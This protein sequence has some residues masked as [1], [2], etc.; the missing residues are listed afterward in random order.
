MV[1]SRPSQGP[2]AEGGPLSAS[3]VCRAGP[4]GRRLGEGL[5][6][7]R[8]HQNPLDRGNWAEAGWSCREGRAA[9]VQ[10]ACRWVLAAGEAGG[11]S[12]KGPSGSG[13]EGLQGGRV[14]ASPTAQRWGHP[15][16]SRRGHE[17]WRGGSSLVPASAPSF[18]HSKK[19]PVSGHMPST[20]GSRKQDPQSCPLGLAIQ[21][22][23][24]MP[25]GGGG[26]AQGSGAFQT[27]VRTCDRVM[28]MTG[29]SPAGTAGAKA[30]GRGVWDKEARVAEEAA[31]GGRG[32]ETR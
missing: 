26:A 8:L 28:R 13:G 11:Q 17:G 5:C 15:R 25:P 1:E 3:P 16:A 9:G 14:P 19:R 10:A 22:A 7:W 20:G 12:K 29:C 30:R 32:R 27:R 21:W 6:D 24:S 4:W 23:H 18:V 31:R 2:P